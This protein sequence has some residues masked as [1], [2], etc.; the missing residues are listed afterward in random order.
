LRYPNQ[1]K[2]TWYKKGLKYRIAN[3]IQNFMQLSIQDLYNKAQEIEENIELYSRTV[4]RTSFTGTLKQPASKK[5]EEKNTGACYRCNKLGH[6]ARD[7]Y[8]NRTNTGNVKHFVKQS[9]AITLQE[10]EEEKE[11]DIYFDKLSVSAVDT[12]PSKKRIQKS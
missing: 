8:R 5:E 2:K 12:F 6:L 9:Q 4:T 1:S 3:R 11:D 10:D 7:C